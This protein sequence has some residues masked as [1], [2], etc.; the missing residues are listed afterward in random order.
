[1]IPL[2]VL[3]SSRPAAAVGGGELTYIPGSYS[4]SSAA[5]VTTSDVGIG[6]ASATREV[7]IAVLHSGSLNRECTAMI[8]GGIAATRDASGGSARA[9]AQIFRASVPT[10][11]AADVVTT[12]NAT[13]HGFDLYV[14]TSPAA[15]TVVDTGR[16]DSDGIASGLGVTVA[17]SP[18]GAVL[19]LASSRS[20]ILTETSFDRDADRDY[21]AALGRVPGT[22][23]AVTVS[24]TWGGAAAV[25][26][27]RLIAASYT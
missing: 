12:W 15:L 9:G 4:G 22:G 14:Y 25:G 16:A 17:T 13:G 19:A 6:G 21:E 26:Y 11:T 1:M 7:V 5:T 18:G 23:S 3:A 2:G 8:I 20:V 24:A 10:G 27:G